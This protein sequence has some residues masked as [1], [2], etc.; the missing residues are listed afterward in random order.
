VLLLGGLLAACAPA[1]TSSSWPAVRQP[2]SGWTSI[3]SIQ[4]DA[5]S[6]PVSR[7][8]FSGEP[9]AVSVACTGAGTVFAVVGWMGVSEPQGAAELLTAA[10]A[11]GGP[12]D[13]PIAS[14]IELNR[15]PTGETDVKVFVLEAESATR[16]TTYSV[17]LEER[18]P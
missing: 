7:L 14:R 18:L 13:P 3:G 4:G 17:S 12:A 16:P 6:A 9:V 2:P 8:V 5:G 1:P 10:F 11:C 15:A